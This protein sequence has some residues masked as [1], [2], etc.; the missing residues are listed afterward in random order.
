MAL[1]DYTTVKTNNPKLFG[2]RPDALMNYVLLSENLNI[3]E[4]IDLLQKSVALMPQ[5]SLSNYN[6]GFY[7]KRRKE[8][9]QALPH[10]LIAYKQ[11]VKDVDTIRE[12]A[13]CYYITDQSNEAKEFYKKGAELGCEYCRYNLELLIEKGYI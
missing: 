10:L 5:W 7:L 12:I 3:D 11:N 8:Y 13:D 6:L 9:K 2:E 1:Q 4:K